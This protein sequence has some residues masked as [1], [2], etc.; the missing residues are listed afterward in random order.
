[1]LGLPN[2]LSMCTQGFHASAAD[3]FQTSGWMAL[4]AL[5]NPSGVFLPFIDH[6][7]V[8]HGCECMTKVSHYKSTGADKWPLPQKVHVV[9]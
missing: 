2:L 6:V 5:S 4:A 3:A 8:D 1:M 7:L 9:L